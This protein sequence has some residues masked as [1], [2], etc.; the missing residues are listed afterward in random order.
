MGI[1]RNYITP[2]VGLLGITC[3]N[4]PYTLHNMLNAYKETYLSHRYFSSKWPACFIKDSNHLFYCTVQFIL[5][6]RHENCHLLYHTQQLSLVSSGSSAVLQPVI[7][8]L[9]FYLLALRKARLLLFTI[10]ARL[11]LYLCL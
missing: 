9:D 8:V 4:F 3:L 11:R 6:L 5:V 2:P 1:G 7:T 10:Y